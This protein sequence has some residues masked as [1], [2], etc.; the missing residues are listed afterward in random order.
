[1][2]PAASVDVQVTVVDPIGNVAGALLVIVGTPQL[3][4]PVGAVPKLTPLA[5]HVPASTLTV[6]SAGHELLVGL[7]LSTTVT[8]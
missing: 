7:I 3:S 2:F 5:V 6:T 4:V 1:M 8:V